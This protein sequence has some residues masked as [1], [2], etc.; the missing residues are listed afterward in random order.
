MNCILTLNT[1]ALLALHHSAKLVKRFMCLAFCTIKDSIAKLKFCNIIHSSNYEG[2]EDFNKVVKG[3][4]NAKKLLAILTTL[5][6][7]VIFEL[8]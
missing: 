6:C 3:L 1:L 2:A 7:Y 8:C 4:R 5:M